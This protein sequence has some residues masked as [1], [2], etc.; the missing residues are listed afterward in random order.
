MLV[1]QNQEGGNTSSLSAAAKSKSLITPEIIKNHAH[2]LQ[3]CMNTQHFNDFGLSICMNACKN[4][5][6]FKIEVE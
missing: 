4:L 6:Y 3:E 2:L 1:S 5:F